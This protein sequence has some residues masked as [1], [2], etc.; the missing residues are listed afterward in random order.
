M[1][2]DTHEHAWIPIPL[3]MGYYQCACGAAG[4]RKGPASKPGPI[5]ALKT[6][7]P[8]D[9]REPS[10]VSL[11]HERREE[12]AERDPALRPYETAAGAMARRRGRT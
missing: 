12:P 5:V 3:R 4:M 10:R 1:S 9:Y 8:A 2:D 6:R 7:S 11:P